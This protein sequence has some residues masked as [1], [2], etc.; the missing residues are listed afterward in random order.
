MTYKAKENILVFLSTRKTVSMSALL[1][2][3]VRLIQSISLKVSERERDMQKERERARWLSE[4]RS[5]MK[6]VIAN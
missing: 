4:V 6:H 3:K 1:F 2:G 5:E